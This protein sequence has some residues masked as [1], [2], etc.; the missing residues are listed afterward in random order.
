M[1]IDV[2][3]IST[4][5]MEIEQIILERFQSMPCSIVSKIKECE[6]EYDRAVSCAIEDYMG[7]VRHITSTENCVCCLRSMR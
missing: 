4:I 5:P 3:D 6:I 2:S 1:I 7:L